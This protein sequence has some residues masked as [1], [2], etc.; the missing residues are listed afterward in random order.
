MSPYVIEPIGHVESPLTDRGQAPKQGDEGAPEA[1][2]VFEERVREGLRDLREGDE[3]IVLTWLDRA[4]RDVLSVHPRGDASR[5]RQ[6]VF[7]TRSPDRPNPVGLHR[8]GVVAVEGTRLRVRD[9]EALDGTPI[10][11]VKPVLDRDTER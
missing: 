8:V 11:D 10:V 7:S 4:V 2:L 5:P 1:W 6:G 3:V 9:L